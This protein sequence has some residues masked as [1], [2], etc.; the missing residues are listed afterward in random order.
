MSGVTPLFET[1]NKDFNYSADEIDNVIDPAMSLDI[2]STMAFDFSGQTVTKYYPKANEVIQFVKP[3][4]SNAINYG[5]YVKYDYNGVDVKANNN[6]KLGENETLVLYYKTEDSDS[7]PYT[8]VIYGHNN[9][10]VNNHEIICPSFDLIA[11]TNQIQYLSDPSQVPSTALTTK[12]GQ[13]IQIKEKNEIVL[14]NTTNYIYV[15][16]NEV[17]DTNDNTKHYQINL[18]KE[19]QTDSTCVY[20]ITLQ[21]EQQLIYASD[22]LTYINIVGSGTKV[23][24]E[25]SKDFGD[26]YSLD[27]PIV[28]VRNI[29]RNGVQALSGKW[30]KISDKITLL[31]QDFLNVQ[32]TQTENAPDIQQDAWVQITAPISIS[33]TIN[34]SRNGLS[35]A[36]STS[37]Q[38]GKA[39]GTVNYT[40]NYSNS[41][42]DEINSANLNPNLVSDFVTDDDYYGETKNSFVDSITIQPSDYL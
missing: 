6:H 12:S 29:Q 13:S 7:A 42:T 31:A 38:N 19:S 34:L 22:K 24:I 18:P 5:S 10:L 2:V 21:N 23:S 28:S 3:Q 39:I 37:I 9:T 33:G 40:D 15:I 30:K 32:G 16:G 41:R 27:N 36:D 8:R 25:T 35:Y 26:F 11:T 20:A 14:N 1:D 17:Q 4:L